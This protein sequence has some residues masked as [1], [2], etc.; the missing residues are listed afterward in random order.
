MAGLVHLTLA[1]TEYEA[2]MVCALLRTEGITCDH[3]PTNVSVG[4]MDGLSR[5]GPREIIVEEQELSRAHELLE[6]SRNR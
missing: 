5:G 3:R 2:E 6:A 4:A 1:P